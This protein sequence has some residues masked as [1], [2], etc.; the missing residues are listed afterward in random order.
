M[1]ENTK[2]GQNRKLT[3]LFIVLGA[4]IAAAVAVLIIVLLQKGSQSGSLDPINENVSDGRLT[5]DKAAVAMDQ[6]QLQ[7]QVDEAFDEVRDGYIRIRHKSEAVSAD[8]KSFECYIENVEA[9]KYD[10]YF[11]IYKDNTAKEQILLTGL[12]PPGSGLESF[13]SDIKLEPGTYEA[14]LVI[15]QVEEDHV[16]IH[17]GQLFLALDL[18]VNG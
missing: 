14:L 4:V 18:V 3:I 11:N 7:S 16:T 17:G 8:G 15:T 5:Y 13:R 12:I 6:E 1:S 10:V 9:N 2:K